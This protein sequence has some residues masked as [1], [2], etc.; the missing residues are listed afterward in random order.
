MRFLVRAIVVVLCLAPCATTAAS[1]YLEDLTSPELAHRIAAGA[2]V[3]LVPIGGTE[4]NGPHMTLGKHNVRVRILAG[5]IAARLGDAIVAPVIAYV[6]E[7][8][9]RPP[10]GHMRWSGTISVPDAAFDAILEGA[11]RSLKQHGFRYVFFVGDH[12]GYQKSEARVAERLQ[13]EWRSDPSCRVE[14][15]A[16]YYDVAQDPYADELMRRGYGRAEIGTHAGLA[17]TSLALAVDP[18]LVR[19]E[20]LA[21][22]ATRYPGVAGDPRRAG[23][24]LGEI[25]VAQI[26]RSSVAAIRAITASSTQ[27][28]PSSSPRLR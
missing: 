23:A 7:G 18:S 14:A 28:A 1:V 12:G 3:A 9:I 20:V 8:S 5:R 16:V 2:T 4:Q 6:P 25:G 27:S 17:D 11:A 26:V 10:A 19:A 13:R 24:A 15:L 22:P 21:D